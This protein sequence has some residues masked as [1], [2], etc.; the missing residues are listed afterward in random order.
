MPSHVFKSGD[1][2]CRFTERCGHRKAYDSCKATAAS[3][4]KD[5]RAKA[6]HRPSAVPNM[7]S[8]TMSELRAALPRRAYWM[9]SGRFAAR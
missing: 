1:G 9:C 4:C 7:S 5:W 3:T 2:A 8:G 6:R